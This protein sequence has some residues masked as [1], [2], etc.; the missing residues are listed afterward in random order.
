MRFYANTD[1]GL[2]R[3][4][5]EDCFVNLT[6]PK[7]RFFCAVFDGMGGAA[8]GEIASRIA[9]E[10][11][12]RVLRENR[13]GEPSFLLRTAALTANEEILR[14]AEKNPEA[15]GMG[16]TVS[17]L[18]V[19]GDGVYSLS[20]GDS[21]TY[22]L[23]GGELARLT[24]DDSYVQAL[25]DRGAITREEAEYHPRRNVITAALGALP[26]GLPRV[27]FFAKQ[28]G[29]LYL[30]CTDG[31]TGMVSEEKIRNIL[32]QGMPPEEAVGYLLAAANEGGGRDNITAAVL[33]L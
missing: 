27:N 2:R 33:T 18:F 31:L 11:F 22:R 12:L 25:I 26:K 4:Q 8:A 6:L 1:K 5:N 28:A 21:R 20:I 23:R 3:L 32:C 10:S 19:G 14:Y 7:N 16:T 15:A 29:D 17:A 9:G 13:E 24:R 30:L